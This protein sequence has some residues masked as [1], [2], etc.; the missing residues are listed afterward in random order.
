MWLKLIATKTA[1]CAQV[2]KPM[3]YLGHLPHVEQF[4][5]CCVH[6]YTYTFMYLFVHITGFMRVQDS[7]NTYTTYATKTI[8]K[9]QT[10]LQAS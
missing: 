5:T 4:L 3:V 7:S 9:T 1:L 2:V 8:R 10:W 6:I